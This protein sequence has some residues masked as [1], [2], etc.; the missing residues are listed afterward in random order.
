MTTRRQFL[1]G[2]LA[3]GTALPA[4]G[5]VTGCEPVPADRTFSGSVTIAGGFTVPTGKVWAFDPAVSTTVRVRA[6]VVVA[7]TLRMRPANPAVVHRLVFEQVD[8][9]A[10]VGGGDQVLASDVGLWVVDDGILDAGGSPKQAWSRLTGSAPAGATSVQV[11]DATGWRVGDTVAIVPTAPVTTPGFWQR[12]D[13]RQIT[14]LSGN[15]LTVAPLAESHPSV[16]DQAGRTHTAE[17]LNLTRN[18]RITGT[19]AG[20]AHVMF[21]R[22]RRP[23]SVAHVELAHL[24]PGQGATGRYALHHHRSGDASNGT[25]YV[26][27][28]AHDIGG[29]VFVPHL[30]HGITYERCVAH[31]TWDDAFWWDPV[32]GNTTPGDATNRVWW[33]DCVASKTQW[34]PA[35]RAYRLAAFLLMRDDNAQAVLNRL[36][37]CV[38]VGTEANTENPTDPAFAD[39]AGFSWPEEVQGTEGVWEF[40]DNLAHNC[41]GSGVFTWQNTPSPHDVG[42]TTVYNTPV[43]LNHGAYLNRYRYHDHVY[44]GVRQGVRMHA[45]SDRV[46]PALSIETLDVLLAPG[47]ASSVYFTK[48]SLRGQ[49]V[50]FRRCRFRGAATASVIDG[51]GDDGGQVPTRATFVDCDWQPGKPHVTFAPGAAAGALITEVTGGVETARHTT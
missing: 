11:T 4:R 12:Y 17:V 20:R 51:S 15:S 9:S 48:H 44:W 28:V 37:G 21:L 40:H 27:L 10:F 33:K 22:T 14:G 38:A 13:V 43:G 36:T 30:S 50:V 1:A 2:A 32:P 8:E 35:Y 46:S 41:R 29:H 39:S 47:S 18:V 3:T 42:A 16:I 49:P 6:N 7:G 25:R 23:Q 5:I 26:G 45:L 24:G 34:A 19:A 31:D